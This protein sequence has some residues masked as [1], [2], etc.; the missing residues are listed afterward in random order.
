MVRK[1]SGIRYA[2]R[3][4]LWTYWDASILDILGANGKT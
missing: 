3:D 1:N 4:H 2:V